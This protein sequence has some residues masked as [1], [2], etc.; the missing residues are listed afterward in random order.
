MAEEAAKEAEKGGKKKL[1][2]GVVAALVVAG[3]AYKFV[4]APKPEPAATTEG[5]AAK[6]E[7]EIPGVAVPLEPITLNLRDGRYLKVG[8]AFVVP[9]GGGGGHGGSE[10]PKVRFAS[11]LDSAIEV[12]GGRTFEELVTPA[13]REDAKKA[14]LEHFH[15]DEESPDHDIQDVLFT[16]F[17]MQ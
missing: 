17:V 16:Q 15:E 11:A 7:E 3:G 13:G 4:L 5:A 9:E 6:V 10:D 12:L 1:V 14:L 2:I 8:L